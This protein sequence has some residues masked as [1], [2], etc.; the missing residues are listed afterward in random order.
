MKKK[1]KKLIYVGGNKHERT[2]ADLFSSLNWH[3]SVAILIPRFQVTSTGFRFVRFSF[4]TDR[5][6]TQPPSRVKRRETCFALRTRRSRR[7]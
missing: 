5:P 4:C 2:E 6:Y 7:H 1:M 3:F